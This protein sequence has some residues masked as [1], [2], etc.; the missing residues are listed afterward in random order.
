METHLSKPIA[1]QPQLFT[2]LGQWRTI[3]SWVRVDAG[4]EKALFVERSVFGL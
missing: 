3:G 4:A 1:L 2:K